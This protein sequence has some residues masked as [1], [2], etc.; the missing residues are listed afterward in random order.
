MLCMCIWEPWDTNFH[1][2]ARDSAVVVTG[3]VASWCVGGPGV[4]VDGLNGMGFGGS[5]SRKERCC[6]GQSHFEAL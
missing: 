5:V 3:C 4:A 6:L 1:L 2:N